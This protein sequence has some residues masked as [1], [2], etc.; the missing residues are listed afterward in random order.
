MVRIRSSSFQNYINC[1]YDREKYEAL[2]I[3]YLEKSIYPHKGYKFYLN[4]FITYLDTLDQE[5]RTDDIR[6]SDI[7]VDIGANVGLFAIQQA[8]KCRHIFCIEPLYH[9]ILNKNIELNEIKNCMVI[10]CGLSGKKTEMIEYHNKKDFINCKTLS[11]IKEDI[12]GRIDFLKLDCEG[13]EWSIK[14][15]ELKSIRR[16]E[17]E[18][19][20]FK[21]ENPDVFYNLLRDAGFKFDIFERGY[22]QY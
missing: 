15:E 4:E 18:L 3:S 20:L 21:K 13:G 6:K 14:S 8:K 17:I 16:L 9:N 5:Y 12:G 22:I 2:P 7:V 1:R 10:N 11:E 19:H